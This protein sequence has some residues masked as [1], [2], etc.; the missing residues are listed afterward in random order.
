VYGRR[1]QCSQDEENPYTFAADQLNLIASK[2]GTARKA[3]LAQV[4]PMTHDADHPPL[5]VELKRS[6]VRKVAYHAGKIS[7]AAGFVGFGALCYLTGGV[8]AA[9]V[10]MGEAVIGAGFG[11][12]TTAAAGGVAFSTEMVIRYQ[13]MQWWG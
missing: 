7:V 10:V 9:L 2:A 6:N 11:A 1:L 8:C 3:F 4:G 13:L 5:I 12:A